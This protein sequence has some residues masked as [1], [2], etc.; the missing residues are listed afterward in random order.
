[1]EAGS[2][3]KA[4]STMWEPVDD[5]EREPDVYQK[6]ALGGEFSSTARSQPRTEV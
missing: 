4:W 5:G 2:P 3:G 6:L 1:M